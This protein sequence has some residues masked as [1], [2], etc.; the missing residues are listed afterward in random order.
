MR[1]LNGN[2]SENFLRQLLKTCYLTT[3]SSKMKVKLD[4]Q[5]VIYAGI[6]LC[7]KSIRFDL[8]FSNFNNLS[9][10][11]KIEIFQPFFSWFHKSSNHDVLL[12][13]S[14]V[15][16]K[17]LPFPQKC[18]RNISVKFLLHNCILKITFCDLSRKFSDVIIDLLQ[19]LRTYFSL[20]LK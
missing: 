11:K 9:G 3:N 15:S 4:F 2:R 5:W 1:I 16:M 8:I 17:D 19:E 7:I 10:Q 18:N 14:L 6:W 20:Q 12:S 13:K